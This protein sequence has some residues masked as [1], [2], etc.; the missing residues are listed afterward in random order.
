MAWG[1][2]TDY[3]H[4]HSPWLWKNQ[5]RLSAATGPTLQGHHN[6]WDITLVAVQ[7]SM[8]PSQHHGRWAL[9]HQQ[10][11]RWKQR[12]FT[13]AWSSLPSYLQWSWITFFRQESSATT[14]PTVRYVWVSPMSSPHSYLGA[15]C[16]WIHNWR[17]WTLDDVGLISQLDSCSNSMGGEENE[18]CPWQ[19]KVAW[20]GQ[21]S[22]PP[23][24]NKSHFMGLASRQF[25]DVEQDYI[26]KW[27]LWKECI[28]R[29]IIEPGRKN[30]YKLF[31]WPLLIPTGG[32]KLL[33]DTKSLNGQY[34]NYFPSLNTNFL[35]VLHFSI[36]LM[37]KPFIYEE[38]LITLSCGKSML[39]WA[40]HRW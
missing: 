19:L 32:E 37:S 6:C 27:W 20:R 40:T 7:D 30:L 15:I 12:P 4:L 22:P 3:G 33:Y 36:I 18:G 14:S 29:A 13:S 16:G 2:S 35:E 21:I 39:T 24:K 23:R 28:S 9:K 8:S 5:T 10:G 34:S 17:I 26:L 31:L 38:F 11:F 25:M 1:C